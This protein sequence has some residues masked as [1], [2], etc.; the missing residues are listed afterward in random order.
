MLALIH[1]S[2]TV[3]L[4]V[5]PDDVMQFSLTVYSLSSDKLSLAPNSTVDV[6]LNA[7]SDSQSHAVS[8]LTN[9]YLLTSSQTPFMIGFI[10]VDLAI[11]LFSDAVNDNLFE[12]P[13]S[14]ILIFKIQESESNTI[15]QPLLLTVVDEFV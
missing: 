1:E 6:L 7:K 4:E 8:W 12:P 13:I 11:E 15:L 10:I 2:L 14:A 3:T 5:I 9:I